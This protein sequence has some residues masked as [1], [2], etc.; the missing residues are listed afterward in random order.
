[1]DELVVE[2]RNEEGGERMVRTKAMR[3]LALLNNPKHRNHLVGDIN[4]LDQDDTA[5]VGGGDQEMKALTEMN[6]LQEFEQD[7]WS[8]GAV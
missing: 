7:N 5:R 2:H 1:V 8:R 6:E 3:I 4:L